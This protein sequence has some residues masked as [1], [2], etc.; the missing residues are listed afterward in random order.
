MPCEDPG[1]FWYNENQAG[2]GYGTIA[3]EYYKSQSREIEIIPLHGSIE[4]APLLGISDVIGTG[5]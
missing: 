5:C 4:L 3:R 1:E 2:K